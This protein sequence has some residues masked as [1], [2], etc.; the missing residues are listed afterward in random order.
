MRGATYAE[1]AANV[2]NVKGLLDPVPVPASPQASTQGQE[3]GWCAVHNT[4]MHL[5]QGKD[6]RTWWSHR[7][8]EGGFCKGK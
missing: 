4:G 1:F 8:P 6:G 3:P 7:L 5:N 2:A